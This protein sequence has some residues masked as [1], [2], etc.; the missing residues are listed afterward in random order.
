VLNRNKLH[1]LAEEKER[2]GIE[3]SGTARSGKEKR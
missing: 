3:R 1:Q 2:K